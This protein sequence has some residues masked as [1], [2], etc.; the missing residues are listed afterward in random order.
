MPGFR[1][2]KRP[3]VWIERTSFWA[4]PGIKWSFEHRLDTGGGYGA[5]T[6]TTIASTNLLIKDSAFLTAGADTTQQIGAGTFTSDNNGVI[7]TTEGDAMTA[8]VDE[9]FEI[10]GV[11]K[12]GLALSPLKADD[13]FQVR[14]MKDLAVI[15][16]YMLTPTITLANPVASAD[17]MRMI[18][19]S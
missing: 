9:E 2:W 14:V 6:A 19:V 16:T 18:G 10:E 3:T 15:G 13:K 4:C 7:E 12:T 8:V 17:R 11:F 1:N 5:W